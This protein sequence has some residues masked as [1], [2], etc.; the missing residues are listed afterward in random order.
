MT[1]SEMSKQI[2]RFVLFGGKAAPGYFVA[3]LIIK[4]INSVAHVINHDKDTFRQLKVLF[5]ADY[6]VS[7]AEI[8]VPASDLSQ[9]ISTA[10]T[11]VI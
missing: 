3:K 5:L 10:G 8:I 4:L 9:H 2:P 1:P 7:L 11:E 6:N